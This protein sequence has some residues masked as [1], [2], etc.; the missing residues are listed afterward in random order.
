VTAGDVSTRVAA[1]A[2]RVGLDEERAELL[3]RCD[4]LGQA[5]RHA[6]ADVISLSLGFNLPLPGLAG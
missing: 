1:R 4:Q 2:R 6:Q 3:L 5:L